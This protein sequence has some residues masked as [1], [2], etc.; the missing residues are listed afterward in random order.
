M[1]AWGGEQRE[2]EEEEQEE[3]EGGDAPSSTPV[4]GKPQA[5]GGDVGRRVLWDQGSSGPAEPPAGRSPY[6]AVRMSSARGPGSRARALC[7]GQDPGRP[8]G[9]AGLEPESAL[10]AHAVSV[11]QVI[12]ESGGHYEP[13]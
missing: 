10:G 2:E 8:L 12:T 11:G 13:S 4:T 1:K 9:A 3:G 7:C 6:R 5:S